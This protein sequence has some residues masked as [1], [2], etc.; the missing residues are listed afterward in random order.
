MNRTTLVAALVAV[1]GIVH[2]SYGF[3][4][5]QLSPTRFGIGFHGARTPLGVRW[6]LGEKVALDAGFGLASSE[7]FG[8]DKLTRITGD[9]GVPFRLASW[10][11]VGV[12]LRPGVEYSS[13]E[14]P[15]G[16]L[17]GRRRRITFSP[18]RCGSRPRFSWSR[19]SASRDRS[20]SRTRTMIAVPSGTCE[21]W[22]TTGGNFTDVGFHVYFGGPR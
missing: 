14:V 9:L 3:A 10:D 18:P 11:R 22:S 6:W 1:F 15:D 2:A 7:D 4:E 13:E 16:V 19:G 17:H 20:A 8:G 12:H 21:S 5:E